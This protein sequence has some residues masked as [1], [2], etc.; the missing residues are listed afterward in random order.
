[1]Y[2][3]ENNKYCLEEGE[4]MLTKEREKRPKPDMY[5]GNGGSCV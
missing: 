5:K 3:L 1:M 4:S 2:I